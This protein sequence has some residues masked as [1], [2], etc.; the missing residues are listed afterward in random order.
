MGLGYDQVLD[1]P[2]ICPQYTFI[3]ESDILS[4]RS[5]LKSYFA[6]IHDKPSLLNFRG[7]II[8]QI[9]LAFLL[10]YEQIYI[11]G[12]DFDLPNSYWYTCELESGDLFR[13]SKLNNNI[14]EKNIA[15]Y[16]KILNSNMLS[17]FNALSEDPTGLLSHNNSILATLVRFRNWS[18]SL[19]SYCPKIIFLNTSS[20]MQDYIV[21]FLPDA[22]FY[23]SLP[24]GR[25]LIFTLYFA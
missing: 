19:R 21:S 1:S 10:D 22:Q 25:I 9:S 12:L 13:F 24:R 15:I 2:C 18:L 3:N 20:F 17:S 7:S 23:R 4:I 6:S 5:D 11:C 16:S 8:R 14:V